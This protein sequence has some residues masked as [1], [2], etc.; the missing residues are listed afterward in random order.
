MSKVAILE[1]VKGKLKNK[2][3]LYFKRSIHYK[4]PIKAK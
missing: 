4:L 3:V 2:F 1:L